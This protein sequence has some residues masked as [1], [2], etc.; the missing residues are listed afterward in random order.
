MDATTFVLVCALRHYTLH[1]C[2]YVSSHVA[3]W[4]W[5]VLCAGHCLCE[6]GDCSM[7]ITSVAATRT[8][9]ALPQPPRESQ[10]ALTRTFLSSE[11]H[12]CRP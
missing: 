5:F 11:L 8:S 1:H 2:K 12:E 10:C 3:L 4:L 7:H 6:F 9:S